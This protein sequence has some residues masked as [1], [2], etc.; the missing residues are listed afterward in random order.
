MGSVKIYI[1]QINDYLPAGIKL[2]YRDKK[3]VRYSCTLTVSENTHGALVA[4]FKMV[5][6]PF[7]TVYP[8]HCRVVGE[9]MVK[10]S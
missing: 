4:V 2:W 9:R 7:L 1:I 8:N 3:T 6:S 10:K 5:D